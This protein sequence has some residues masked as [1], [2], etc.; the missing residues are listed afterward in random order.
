MKITFRNLKFRN[1]FKPVKTSQSLKTID[2]VFEGFKMFNNVSKP[3]IYKDFRQK[4]FETHQHLLSLNQFLAK[5]SK[6]LKVSKPFKI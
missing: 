2:I 1:V 6:C 4:R 3:N 5:V